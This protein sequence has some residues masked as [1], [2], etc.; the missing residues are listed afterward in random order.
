MQWSLQMFEKVVLTGV[1]QCDG[2]CCR[3]L[4]SQICMC[5]QVGEVAQRLLQTMRQQMEDRNLQS[6]VRAPPVLAAQG[7]S[8]TALMPSRSCRC[9]HQ[10]CCCFAQLP[11]T[12]VRWCIMQLQVC[13][14][15]KLVKTC[16]MCSTSLRSL[17]SLS[18]DVQHMEGHNAKLVRCC[19]VHLSSR[20][21]CST[22]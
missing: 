20:P 13:Q 2:C 7:W 15:R 4:S 22:R 11:N 12:H 17:L 6:K 5:L 18:R 14:P 19:M 10:M 8:G 21:G 16:S 1:Q 9:A 3:R